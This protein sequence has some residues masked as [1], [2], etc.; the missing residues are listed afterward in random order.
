MRSHAPLYEP[1][2]RDGQDLEHPRPGLGAHVSRDPDRHGSRILRGGRHK[3]RQARGLHEAFE[4]DLPS[5]GSFSPAANRGAQGTQDVRDVPVFRPIK[6][7]SPSRNRLASVGLFPPV[8]IAICTAPR[9]TTAGA[10]KSH[11][12]GVSTVFTQIRRRR[13]AKATCRFTSSRSVA[14]IMRAQPST[15][16]S[17]NAR[18]ICVMTPWLARRRK[19]VVTDGLTTTTAASTSRSPHT[20]RSATI[21]PPTTRQRRWARSRKI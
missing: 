10:M 19:A 1:F 7:S 14:A 5:L 21:P 18:E 3:Q 13:A 17:R 6:A 15:S 4:H 11:A 2:D 12:A 9:R 20:F 16:T 8:E